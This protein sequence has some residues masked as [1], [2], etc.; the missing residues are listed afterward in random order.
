M[1]NNICPDCGDDLERCD[2]CGRAVCLC[3]PPC[4]PGEP[5]YDRWCEWLPTEELVCH[6]CY[7]AHM[8][9]HEYRYHWLSEPGGVGLYAEEI[10]EE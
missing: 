3:R 9:E 4:E 2:H 7:R 10:F 5:A 8:A 6:E 1:T